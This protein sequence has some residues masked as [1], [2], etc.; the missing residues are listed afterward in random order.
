[1]ASRKTSTP[2]SCARRDQLGNVEP[3][4]ARIADPTDRDQPRPMI[5]A[6]QDRVR[7]DNAVRDRHAAASPRPARPG[8]ATDTRLEG[9]SL[10]SVTRLSPASHARPSATRLIPAVV[11]WTKAIS[12]GWAWI[13][14]GA[15]GSYRLDPVGPP[16]PGHIPLPACLLAPLRGRYPVSERAAEPRRRGPD[17]PSSR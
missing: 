9:N 16:R 7:L 8:S 10:A 11:L 17:R 3:P 1:M 12:S 14:P 4:P 2:R 13:E 6:S 15:P 5:A